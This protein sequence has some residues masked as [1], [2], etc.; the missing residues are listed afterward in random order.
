MNGEG[1]PVGERNRFV[2]T[3]VF[4]QVLIAW[5]GYYWGVFTFEWSFLLL[6]G[7]YM[8]ASGGVR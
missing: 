1:R 5:G 8:I 3:L 7:V 2:N 4:I 6:I